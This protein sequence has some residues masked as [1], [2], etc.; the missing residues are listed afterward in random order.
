MSKDREL[1]KEYIKAVK[2]LSGGRIIPEW[3]TIGKEQIEAIERLIGEEESSIAESEEPSILLCNAEE[4]DSASTKNYVLKSTI[5]K[6][7]RNLRQYVCDNPEA[8][9]VGFQ[10]VIAVLKELLEE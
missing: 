5:E 9:L 3:T 8:N 2:S 1:L 4:T 7:I 10:N 6:K